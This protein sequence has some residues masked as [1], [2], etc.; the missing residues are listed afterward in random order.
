MKPHLLKINLKEGSSFNI[1]HDVVPHFYNK[2]HYHP[3]IELVYIMEGSGQQFI[4]DNI[5]IFKKGDMILLGSNLPHLWRTDKMYMQADPKLRVRAL[6]LH[7][8]PGCLGED[9]FRLKENAEILKLL[10]RARYAVR[11]KNQTRDEVAKLMHELLHAT[12]TQ[13][14]ILLLQILS[15]IASSEET[16]SICKL[17]IQLDY[18]PAESERINNIYQYVLENYSRPITLKEIAGVAH[19]GPHSFC[20]FFKLRT[21]KTFSRFLIEVR[22]GNACKL[23]AE[24]NKTVAEIC[25]ECGFN[26]F[27]NFNRQFKMLIGKTPLEHRMIYQKGII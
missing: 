18:T 15:T 7:F 27:S 2:W 14:I 3:E 25:Y 10:E 24:T 20:R 16:K 9:F 4:G 5:H 21:Q 13:R 12:G 26:S 22:I 19:L 8:L 1:R 17:G 23:L 6:V 11:I